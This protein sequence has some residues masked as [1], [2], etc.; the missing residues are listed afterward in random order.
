MPVPNILDV[1]GPEALLRAHR[2]RRSQPLLAEKV[3]D[4]LL[5]PAR[6][7]E[8]RGVVVGDQGRARVEPVAPLPEKVQEPSPYLATLHAPHPGTTCWPRAHVQGTPI[9]PAGPPVR[10]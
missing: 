10:A 5:D 9:R 8:D 6:G 3:G 7:Q 1:G 4:E 2:P